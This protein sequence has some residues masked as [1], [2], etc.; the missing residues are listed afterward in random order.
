MSL[1]NIPLDAPNKI[2]QPSAPKGPM[3]VIQIISWVIEG[4]FGLIILVGLLFKLESWQGGSELL[5]LG[6]F[7]LMLFY[8]I[9]LWAI[10]GSKTWLQGLLTIPVGIAMLFCI[11]GMLFRLESWEG[12]SEMTIV[13][14]LMLLTG[15]VATLVLMAVRYSKS[16][17]KPYYLHILIRMALVALLTAP[18]FLRAF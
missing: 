2:Q 16:G 9:M 7:C 15:I 5:I 8:I 14:F 18:G 17:N 4:F 10:A 3:R 11:G 13:G 12:G 6:I 1:A